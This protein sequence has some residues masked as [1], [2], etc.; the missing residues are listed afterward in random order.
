MS[1]ETIFS[2][3]RKY[4]YTLWREWG[5]WFDDVEPGEACAGNRFK[6]AMF[7]GLNPSTADETKDDPTIRR[8]VGFAKAWGYGALCMT[9]LFAFRATDPKIMKKQENPVGEAN[10]HHILRC[11]FGAGIVIAAWGTHGVF[12]NQDLNVKQWVNSIGV[13]LHHLG[14]SKDGHPKHPLYLK[15]DTTPKTFL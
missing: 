6:Y 12:R 8:C 9:N 15:S 14:L 2:P 10:H 7:I 3:C 11:A 1:R 4:R 13:A 5:G